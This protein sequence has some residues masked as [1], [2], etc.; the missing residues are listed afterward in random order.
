MKKLFLIFAVVLLILSSCRQVYIYGPG[1][2]EEKPGANS[3]EDIRGL[4]AE[5]EDGDVINF[6]RMTIPADTEPLEISKS[7][8][9]EGSIDVSESS[10]GR[11]RSMDKSSLFIITKGG[12]LSFG[13]SFSVS[14]GS[15]IISIESLFTVDEGTIDTTNLSVKDN[16]SSFSVIF[17]GKKATAD[18]LKGTIADGTTIEIS[19]DNLYKNTIENSVISKNPDAIVSKIPVPVFIEDSVMNSVAILASRASNDE[20]WQE[21]YEDAMKVMYSMQIPPVNGFVSEAISREYEDTVF[22]FHLMI[23]VEYKDGKYIFT[24]ISEDLALELTYRLSEMSYDY[25][26]V[27]RFENPLGAEEDGRMNMDYYTVAIGEDIKY[28]PSTGSWNGKVTGYLQIRQP[29]T[30]PTPYT[31]SLTESMFHSDYVVNG[32]ATYIAT[33]NNTSIDVPEFDE[34]IASIS[35]GRA[36]VDDLKNAAGWADRKP[37]YEL[38]YYLPKDR[39]YNIYYDSNLNREDLINAAKSISDT[40]IPDIPEA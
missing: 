7:V 39:S 14:I 20:S 40:W 28:D 18:S 17:L 34:S 37:Y 27:N 36:F 33:N 13:S 11:S 23:S 9:F 26:L 29:K 32:I 2:D 6:G 15:D 16:K 4:L 24:G 3:I 19:E 35:D 21:E 12:N 31:Y 30:S 25:I 38:V 5:A 8:K 22:G 1:L 10:A